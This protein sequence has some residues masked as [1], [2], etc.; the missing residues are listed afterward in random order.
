M[1]EEISTAAIRARHWQG[2]DRDLVPV[3]C[4]A[5]D[6][7]RTERDALAAILDMAGEWPKAMA[8]A[9]AAE[10]ALSTEKIV[11]SVIQERAEAAETA[12]QDRTEIDL[13]T[14]ERATR[15]SLELKAAKA[16]IAAA[17]A[18]CD[19]MDTLHGDLR[20]AGIRAALLP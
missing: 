19:Y 11:S 5:L 3:L 18:E 9:E 20:S 2:A 16:R 10:A 14:L 4:D 12:L 15:Q 7:A 17:L 13:L 6:A 1:T 8:R